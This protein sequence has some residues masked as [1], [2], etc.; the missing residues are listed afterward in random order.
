MIFECSWKRAGAKGKVTTEK[1]KVASSF[2]LQDHFKISKF[3]SSRD[4]FVPY[5][6]EFSKRSKNT[7]SVISIGN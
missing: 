2:K 5:R 3:T 7:E 6:F 1:V 4:I